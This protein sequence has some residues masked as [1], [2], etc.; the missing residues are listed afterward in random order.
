MK[1]A[2]LFI[3]AAA[4]VNTAF[5]Q[6][7]K[8][9]PNSNHANKFEQLGTTLPTPN[10]YRTAS[11]APG[12]KYWQQR[13]DY[14]IKATL[15]EAALKLTGTETVTYYNQS[16]DALNYLWI[17]LDENEHSSVNNANYQT[18]SSLP[19]Q[20]SVQQL[21]R[22]KVDKADNG[23]GHIITKLT[24]ATG[25]K[26]NYTINKTMMRIELPQVLKAGQKFVFNGRWQPSFY[27]SAMVPEALRV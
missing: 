13:A 19:A 23:Y 7:I 27:H 12:P 1:K 15:D 11:G 9:N 21:E 4:L 24:D 8:N 14:D 2:L 6:D 25:K 22:M 18:S 17:Q 3:T 5:S 16:P 20:T 10:E 26:L